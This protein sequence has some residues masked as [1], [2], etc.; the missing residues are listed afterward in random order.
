MP[1]HRELTER[2]LDALMAYFEAMS[3]HKRDPGRSV[4]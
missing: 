2:D 4:E 1:A 3:R